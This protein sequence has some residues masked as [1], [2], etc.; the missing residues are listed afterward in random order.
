MFA[1]MAPHDP[2]WEA[3]ARPIVSVIPWGGGISGSKK[4]SVAVLFAAL[5]GPLGLL[6]SSVSGAIYMLLAWCFLVLATCDDWIS[7]D[8]IFPIL[9]AWPVCMIWAALAARSYNENRR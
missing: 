8:T 4:I 1:I 9:V 3:T 7:N 5:F 6:Y 2:S